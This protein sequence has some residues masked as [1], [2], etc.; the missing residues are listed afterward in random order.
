MFFLLNGGGINSPPPFIDAIDDI[1]FD[2]K[3]YVNSIVENI[4]LL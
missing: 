3:E 1:G 4:F 2:D